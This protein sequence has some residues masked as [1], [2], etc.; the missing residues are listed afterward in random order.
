MVVLTMN[1]GEDYVPYCEC[2][3]YVGHEEV[4]YE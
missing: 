4:Y 3:A 1:C 2:L